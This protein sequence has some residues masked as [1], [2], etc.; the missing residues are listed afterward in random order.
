MPIETKIKGKKAELLQSRNKNTGKKTT[1]LDDSSILTDK[2]S[3]FV[4]KKNYASQKKAMKAIKLLL[5]FRIA[6]YE[7]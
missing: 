6:R 5:I 4:L 3:N 1:V 2:Q 7:L